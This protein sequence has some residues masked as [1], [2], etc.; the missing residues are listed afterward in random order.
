MMAGK[1]LVALTRKCPKE[2]VSTTAMMFTST[3]SVPMEYTQLGSACPSQMSSMTSYHPSD[4][5]RELVV[6]FMRTQIVKAIQGTL[7]I[8]GPPT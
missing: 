2:V 7:N 5:I 3:N 1:S 4:L 6:P 8:L